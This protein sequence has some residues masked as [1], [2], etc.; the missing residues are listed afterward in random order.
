MNEDGNVR[1]LGC[2]RAMGFIHERLDGDALDARDAEWLDR[3][4]DTCAECRRA[5]SELEQIQQALRG[6]DVSPFPE[7]ALDEVWDRTTRSTRR[8][9]WADW[10][11]VAAAAALVLAVVGVWYVGFGPVP[12]TEVA[13]SQTTLSDEELARAEAQA[14]Y[15]L[16]LTATALRRSERVALEEVMGK[17]VSPALKKIPLLIPGDSGESRQE[18]RNG[19]SDA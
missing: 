12:E 5:L 2:T 3:H 17:T 6:L 8:P 13:A 19:E 15:V 11:L 9:P 18:R 16:N 1:S 10:R 4:L 14:R 7:D